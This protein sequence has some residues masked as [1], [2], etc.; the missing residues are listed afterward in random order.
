[1]SQNPYKT[2]SITEGVIWKQLLLFFFPIL[3]GTFFQQLYNT[4]DAIIVGRF[5]G[6]EA[7]SAVGGSTG[8]LI[9]L[10]IGFFVGCSSGATV[11]L[12]QFF[13]AKNVKYVQKAVH[14]AMA[15]SVTGG[16]IITVIGILISPWALT[17]MKTPADIMDASLLYIR[18]YFSGT[19]ANLVYNMG[20]GILRA[21]GDS[22]RP[23]YFL[24]AGCFVNILLDILLVVVF[25]L[26]ILGAA[27]ATVLSQLFSAVLVCLVLMRTKECYRFTLSKI[28]FHADILLRIIRIGLP[29]GF[30]SVMYSFSNIIIQSNI[31]TFG[32]DT[33]AAWAAYAKIDALFWMIMGAFGVAVTTFV[34]QNYGAGKMD[35]VKKGVLICLAM[36]MGTAVFCSFVFYLF[37]SYIYLLFTTDAL[38]LKKGMEILHFLAP[39][40]VTYVCIEILSG[41]LRGIGKS[42]VP[43]LLTCFGVCVFR[44]V[45][46]GI[47]VPLRPEITTVIVSYPI[48]WVMTSVLFLIY[49]CYSIRH[50]SKPGLL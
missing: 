26:G 42:L 22:R 29:A 4:A 8:T 2:T 23:L 27:L 39:C 17:L 10:F 3:F 35:R 30:Q 47:T 36:S 14:T 13:G 45:W 16:I 31:N 9:N 43:L 48:S 37:G 28:R 18:I 38:V 19:V 46:I 49:Y 15:F 34:G 50:L 41:A 21:V 25:P 1:M 32:T 5:V 7:L 33:V 12:S 6:K 40:F 11:I 20:A 44:I 24:I